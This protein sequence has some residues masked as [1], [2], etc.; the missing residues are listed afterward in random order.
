MKT[1]R[2]KGR[3]GLLAGVVVVCCLVVSC[4]TVGRYRVMSFLFDGVPPPAGVTARPAR[5]PEGKDAATS[6]FVEG[7][8]KLREAKPPKKIL[9]V[10]KSVH[11]PVAEHKCKECHDE[12]RG[13]GDVQHG[14]AL[15][16]RCHQEQRREAGWDHGPI[17][18]GTCIPCHVPHR[19]TNEHL[20]SAP[21]PDLC[22]GCHVNATA[23]ESGPHEAATFANCTSCHDPHRMY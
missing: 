11:K 23:S 21:V 15:C 10:I 1:L 16:D 22:L 9:P 2:P 12:K 13:V 8:H 14:A 6:V 5:I 7:L 3:A 20:L 17:N 19:S 18:L 4:T